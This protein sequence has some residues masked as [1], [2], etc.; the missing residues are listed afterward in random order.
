VYT[1]GYEIWGNAMADYA[2]EVVEFVQENYTLMPGVDNVYVWNAYY[3]EACVKAGI[4][5]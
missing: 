2:P 3:D 5:N 1:D 4:V